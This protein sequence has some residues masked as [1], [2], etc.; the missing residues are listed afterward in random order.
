MTPSLE[1]LMLLHSPLFL[2]V[3][4]MLQILRMLQAQRL[5]P[6]TVDV[7]VWA[8]LLLLELLQLHQSCHKLQHQ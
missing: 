1:D 8:R 7:Q 2:Q 4:S 5:N 6:V 3:L